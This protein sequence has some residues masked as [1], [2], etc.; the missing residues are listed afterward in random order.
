MGV[1]LFLTGCLVGYIVSNAI[2]RR[3]VERLSVGKLKIVWD[4]EEHQ[5]Y[6]FMELSNPDITDITSRKII[7]LT[8]DDNIKFSQN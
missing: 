6:M 1:I 2:Y 3:L 7:L 8:V 4:R 5:P